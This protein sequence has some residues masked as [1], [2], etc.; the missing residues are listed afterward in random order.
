M[1]LAGNRSL[2]RAVFP[3]LAFSGSDSLGNLCWCT[4]VWD[5]ATLGDRDH[6]GTSS[7]KR[8]SRSQAASPRA[9]KLRARTAA[10]SA[11]TLSEARHTATSY[12]FNYVA[13]TGNINLVAVSA[14][15]AEASERSEASD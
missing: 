1:V 13:D 5:R 2:F 3:S 6:G 9:A 4:L 14:A 12:S 11:V 15:A 7:D 8:G 10:A